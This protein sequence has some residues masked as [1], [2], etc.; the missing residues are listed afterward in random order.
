[1]KKV[2]SSSKSGENYL[3]SSLKKMM[4]SQKR[5]S[6]DSSFIY[7]A[8]HYYEGYIVPVPGTN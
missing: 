7:Y 8:H 2:Q 4:I 1:M 3:I 6:T 5:Y